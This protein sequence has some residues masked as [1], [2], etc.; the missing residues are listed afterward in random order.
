MLLALLPSFNRRTAITLIGYFES[1]MLISLVSNF[2]GAVHFRDLVHQKGS[3]VDGRAF[4]GTSSTKR[5]IPWMVCIKKRPELRCVAAG[6]FYFGIW[7]FVLDMFEVCF[8]PF[9]EMRNSS[10]LAVFCIWPFMNSI[11]STLVM[12][13]KWLRKIQIRLMSSAR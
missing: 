11:A 1:F 12:S 3:F 4:F 6:L 8:Y 7:P 13:D 2:W 10:L 5:A 9:I